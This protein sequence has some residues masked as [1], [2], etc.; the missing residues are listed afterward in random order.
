MAHR[1]QERG[2]EAQ[3]SRGTVRRARSGRRAGA[4]GCAVP[5]DTIRRAVRRSDDGA[6]RRGRRREGGSGRRCGGG[7]NREARKLRDQ[8]LATVRI[9]KVAELLGSTSQEVLALL[10]R[11]HGIEL[12]SASSTIEEVVARSFVERIARQRG[13]SLPSGDMFAETAAPPKPGAKK[14]AAPKKPEPP[15]QTA[16]VLGPPAAGAAARRRASAA[17]R[18]RTASHRRRTRG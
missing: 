6:K 12:K 14:A 3:G 1:H 13:I 7:R 15:K 11:D 2:R 18:C 16:P 10:K 4:D 8:F 17:G 9:Y 5:R